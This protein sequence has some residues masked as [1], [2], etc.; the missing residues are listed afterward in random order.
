MK[1][2]YN[3]DEF[4]FEYLDNMLIAEDKNEFEN[5]LKSCDLC[6]K[7]LDQIKSALQ[8]IKNQPEIEPKQNSWVEFLKQIHKTEKRVSYKVKLAWSVATLCVCLFIAWFFAKNI[9]IKKEEAMLT[10]KDKLSYVVVINNFESER[11]VEL[12]KILSN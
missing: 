8:L 12:L 11:K 2:H 6:A 7:K 9:L 5:H 3:K 1:S 4:Y 10:T